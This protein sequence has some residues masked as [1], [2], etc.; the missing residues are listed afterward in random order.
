[1]S[2]FQVKLIIKLTFNH[3]NCT[4]RR[5]QQQQRRSVHDC[6]HGPGAYKLGL[7]M[8]EH[9]DIFAIYRRHRYYRAFPGPI[10][11]RG[12]RKLLYLY[13]S[14]SSKLRPPVG[15]VIT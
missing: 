7:V 1:M 5:N 3:Q 6:R 9:I 8:G 13:K 15:I 4:V 14:I 10:T 2:D 12:N 11:T